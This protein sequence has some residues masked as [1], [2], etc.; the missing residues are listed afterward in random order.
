M[1]Q[2]VYQKKKFGPILIGMKLRR[3]NM[4]LYKITLY[5]LNYKQLNTKRVKQ[6][7]WKP[8]SDILDI[9][10]AGHFFVFLSIP[11]P[12]KIG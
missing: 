1:V 11:K 9:Y 10:Q 5:S 3:I 7:I 4:K 12:N 2:I 8:C 6:R